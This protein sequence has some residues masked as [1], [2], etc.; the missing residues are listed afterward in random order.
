MSII[1]FS[2]VIPVYNVKE[3]LEKCVNS[4]I[5]QKYDSDCIEIVLVD[6]G[7]K[8][9]S[10]KLCDDLAE[11]HSSLRVIHK[12]NGGLS[13]ARNVG[14][15]C[16][17]GDYVVF[18]DSDDYIEPNTCSEFEKKILSCSIMP[19]IVA[20][21]TCRRN[22]DEEVL[23]LRKSTSDQLVRGTDYLKNELQGNI[24][25]AAWSSIYRRDFLNHNNLRFKKGFL[26]EDEDFTPRAFLCAENVMSTNVVFYN[27]I[28]REGSITTASNK[29]KNA[30][31]IFEIC[32]DLMR[33]YEEISDQELKEL[34]CTHTA[35][36]CYKAMIDAHLYEAENRSIVD[37]SLLKKTSIKKKEKIRYILWNISPRLFYFIY[38]ISI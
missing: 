2:F 10:G 33:I 20:G 8:D 17:N 6:D 12:H 7:S 34:L 24:F 29:T 37:K 31:C 19:D 36:I 16:V 5:H 4:V 35:K 15:D 30:K 18:L 9:G 3:Y 22:H 28:I 11:M 13:D 27:Y 26:H 21:A 38:T 14:M 1:K 32:R 23:L 25:V